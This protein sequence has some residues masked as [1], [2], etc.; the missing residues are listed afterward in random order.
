MTLKKL[1]L[2]SENE[3]SADGKKRSAQKASH[4]SRK[5][6]DPM[7]P[8]MLRDISS[9]GDMYIRPDKNPES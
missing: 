4:L 9:R 7:L 6:T 3:Q 5:S 1:Q 2:K 8:V